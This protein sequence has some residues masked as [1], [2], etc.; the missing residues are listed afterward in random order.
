MIE[1]FDESEFFRM[2]KGR[3]DEQTSRLIAAAA[4]AAVARE[5]VRRIIAASGYTRSQ[6]RSV[7]SKRSGANKA[8]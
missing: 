2:L 6:L 4:T 5:D 3:L 1:K 8:R 7:A